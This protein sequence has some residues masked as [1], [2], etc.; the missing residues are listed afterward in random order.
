[1]CG[2][3]LRMIPRIFVCR[4]ENGSAFLGRFVGGSR[5]SVG[6]NVGVVLGIGR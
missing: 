3:V 6:G 2:V 1:M 4:A 5:S